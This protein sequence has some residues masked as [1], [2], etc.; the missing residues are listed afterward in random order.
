MRS[1]LIH[2]LSG[3][4]LL[5]SASRLL[6]VFILGFGLSISQCIAL[7]Q[8]ALEYQVKAA[9]IYNFLAFTQW[10]GSDLQTINF[11]LYGDA[12]FGQEID[13]LQGKSVGTRSIKILHDINDEQLKQCQAIFFFKSAS[14]NLPGILDSLSDQPILTLADHPDAISKGV[15]INMNLVSEKIVFE[16]NLGSARKSGLDISSKLLQLAVKVHQ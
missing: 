13:K 10:P 9:F 12:H 4:R 15:I 5:R 16:I 8:P 3:H 14:H 1:P 2:R 7:A 11:C 6:L